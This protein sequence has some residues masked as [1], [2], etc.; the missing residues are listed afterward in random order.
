MTAAKPIRQLLAEH[1]FFADLPGTDLDLVAGC[2]R[3]VHF[4]P[5]EPIFREGGAADL[6]YVIRQGRVALSVHSPQGGDLTIAT[7]DDG[8]VLGWS[9]LFPPYRWQFDAHATTD[10]SAV[11]LDGACLRGKCEDDASLGYRLMQRFAQLIQERL[12]DTRL[13]L[14]DLYGRETT[15]RSVAG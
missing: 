11:A 2:G 7:V 5:G 3:N 4:A 12:Q 13:Q 6:F 9:W 14:L 10:T 8:D 1:P 15:G